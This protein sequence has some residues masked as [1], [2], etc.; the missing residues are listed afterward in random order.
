MGKGII[1]SGGLKGEYQVEIKYNRDSFDRE[2][3]RLDEQISRT[4]ALIAGCT[5]P[6]KK[7]IYQ[8]Q[9][10][11]YQ[12]QKE[13]LTKKVPQDQVVSAWCA[14]LTEDLEGEV[15]TIEV[16]GEVGNIQIQPGF[17]N[18]ADYDSARDG[19][20]VP[21]ATL[22]PCG[23]FYNLA[24]LPGWQK[25]KPL[26]RYGTITNINGDIADVNL[27]GT[28]S[29]QQGLDIN[30]ENSLSDVPIE[31][32]SCNGSAFSTG[33]EVLVMFPNNWNQ[34][35]I[36]GFRD[37]PK[38]CGFKVKATFN[39]IIPITGGQTITLRYEFSNGDFSEQ[40]GT[41]LPGGDVD[42]LFSKIT[43]PITGEE[44]N[45]KVFG[46]NCGFT[47]YYRLPESGES[48]DKYG[49]I[50][51][52]THP[53]GRFP[54]P[55]YDKEMPGLTFF[56][57]IASTV[58]PTGDNWVPLIGI[59]KIKAPLDLFDCPHT[60]ED[61]LDVYTVNIEG[62]K[63]A[64]KEIESIPFSCWDNDPVIQPFIQT[65]YPVLPNGYPGNKIFNFSQLLA[66]PPPWGSTQWAK[67]YAYGD[68]NPPDIRTFL[69]M[70]DADGA[71]LSEPDGEIKCE[72]NGASWKVINE[73]EEGA[74]WHYYC[75]E[76][77]PFLWETVTKVT[78]IIRV[79]DTELISE[80]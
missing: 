23:F 15:G 3:E 35:K 21:S 41:V 73:D 7:K 19:Q 58:P 53:I 54:Y 31:Y 1:K 27:E 56:E 20:L 52:R 48:P 36:I 51:T 43:D 33:D 67:Y 2:I 70:C 80:F 10:L 46:S 17:E 65:S 16:P 37:N 5:D 62:I 38:P 44:I 64:N 47:D 49:R 55:W 60:K 32:M 76:G 9:L 8:L 26:F 78:Q 28:T 22:P 74:N 75:Q 12:K 72:A 63:K 25:W 71:I 6:T 42:F 59:T 29:S 79:I 13:E 69:F 39:G 24:M 30:Q 14:D 50:T 68:P 18:N 40:A 45:P 66:D 57:F 61:G 34:P 11:N 4:Q 77:H